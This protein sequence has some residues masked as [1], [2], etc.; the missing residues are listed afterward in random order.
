MKDVLDHLFYDA[1]EQ[2]AI[3]LHGVVDL[4]RI[5]DFSD[6]GCLFTCRGGWTVAY[7]RKPELLDLLDRGDAFLSRLDGEWALDPGD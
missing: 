7:S 1:W 6:K 3:A 2:G 5:A 4:R